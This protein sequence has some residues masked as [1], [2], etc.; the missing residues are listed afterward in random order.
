MRVLIVAGILSVVYHARMMRTSLRILPVIHHLNETLS[1]EQVDLARSLGADG[2]FLISH[3]DADDV[4]VPLAVRVRRRHPGFFVGVNLLSL[5]LSSALDRVV[6]N[7]ECLVDGLWAD[8]PGITSALVTQAARD[9]SVRVPRPPV[10]A[11]VAFKY[12]AHEPD[13]SAAAAE[14][15]RLGFIPTT[16]GAGTG[17]A[18]S[19]EKIA[20]IRKSIGDDALLAIASGMTPQNIGLFAPLLSHVLVSTGISMDEYR[21]DPD[22]FTTF[23]AAAR[24]A[25]R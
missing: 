20:A 9:A 12:Q 16:S 15:L 22:R 13:P 11:S 7:G 14:A 1:V 23:L 19:V 2:V 25:T 17:K 18:P 8:S 10:F 6:S 4:L 3:E 5:S 24:G 21:I